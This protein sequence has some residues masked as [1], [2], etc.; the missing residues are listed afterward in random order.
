M[1]DHRRT[2]RAPL[3]L[4]QLNQFSLTKHSQYCRESYIKY[5]ARN[6][7]NYVIILSF[8]ETFDG[9][10]R[11]LVFILR[12]LTMSFWFYKAAKVRPLSMMKY[13]YILALRFITFGVKVFRWKL[14]H[15]VCTV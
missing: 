3:N 1:F 2:T 9:G 11:W 4:S 13:D 6:Y 8:I 7:S 15:N 10:Y 14:L 5:C 12:R